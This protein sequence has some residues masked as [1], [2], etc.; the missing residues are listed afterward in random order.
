MAAD[1]MNEESEKRAR[2]GWIAGPVI[3][4]EGIQTHD[5]SET[6]WTGPSPDSWPNRTLIRHD[7]RFIL[8]AEKHTIFSHLTNNH[9]HSKHSCIVAT[10]GAK[11]RIQ[12]R[13]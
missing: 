10:G 4:E 8:L 13:S 7:A 5:L 1:S 12:N 9:F 11:P 2:A 3:F 6:I